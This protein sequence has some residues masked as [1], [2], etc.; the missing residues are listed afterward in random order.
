VT[1]VLI[2][3]DTIASAE[4]RHEVP[5]AII[6]PFLYAEHDG[7]PT[8]VLSQLDA[9]SA[10]AARP[11]LRIIGPEALGIDELLAAGMNAELAFLEL[12][13]RAC[14]ELEIRSAAAPPGFPLELADLLRNAGLDLHVDRPLFIDRRRV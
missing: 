10:C 12:A 14:R 9:D 3:A 2:Y 1:D 5:V 4:L 7:I 6:D 13:V 11:D 8:A